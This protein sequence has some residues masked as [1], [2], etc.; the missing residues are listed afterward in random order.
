M[1][2]PAAGPCQENGRPFCLV[3]SCGARLA[4]RVGG[5]CAQGDAGCR[6]LRP[7]GSGRIA[8]SRS[9]HPAVSI[10]VESGSHPAILAAVLRRA[11]DMAI[12]PD[13]PPAPRVLPPAHPVARGG[14]DCRRIASAC[15][16]RYRGAGGTGRSG[17][18]GP[19]ARVVDAKGGRPR[20]CP[21]G[22]WR[23]SPGW[24][25]IPAMRSTRRSAG[26][27]AWVSCAGR[28]GAPVGGGRQGPRGGR[29]G[30]RAGRRSRS[31]GRH[32]LSGG[33]RSCRG[34]GPMRGGL[35]GAVPA[36]TLAAP[37][38]CPGTAG[39]ARQRPL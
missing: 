37:T 12:L 9:G 2:G 5:A 17:A 23:P 15:R 34:A 10:T 6:S 16:A 36:G 32:V 26:G 38:P 20:L 28:C 13:I 18:G 1:L 11:A 25:P 27:L 24:S 39:H 7:A 31:A 29:R 19:T 30:L 14:G 22:G 3:R 35:T 8:P 21:R 33:G 4:D